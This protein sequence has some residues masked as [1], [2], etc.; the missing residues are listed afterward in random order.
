M[1]TFGPHQYST[2]DPRILRLLHFD[3]S[4]VD[5]S[6]YHATVTRVGGAAISGAQVKFGSGSVYGFDASFSAGVSSDLVVAQGPELTG[7]NWTWS[8]WVQRTGTAWVFGL[9]YFGANFKVLL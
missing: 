2:G 1:F 7:K 8:C 6:Q 4:L 3:G 5:S 9:A